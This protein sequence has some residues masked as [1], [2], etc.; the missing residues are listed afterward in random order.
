MINP[1]TIKKMIL[2]RKREGKTL[3]PTAELFDFT[4]YFNKVVKWPDF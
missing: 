3:L 4:N 1:D 2:L